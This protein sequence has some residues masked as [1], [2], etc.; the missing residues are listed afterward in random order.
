M[1][2]KHTHTH[3]SCY[4]H[5]ENIHGIISWLVTVTYALVIKEDLHIRSERS[6]WDFMWKRQLSVRYKIIKVASVNTVH[7]WH[8]SI[9]N[10]L[11]SQTQ[12]LGKP[13]II[14][15][16][17]LGEHKSF[18]SNF[19]ISIFLQMNCY[20]LSTLKKNPPA[21]LW[22]NYLKDLFCFSLAIT[23]I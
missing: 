17:F 21:L 2:L 19:I 13:Q 18:H 23:F 1:H 15:Y 12:N 11:S 9:I 6:L 14:S 5:Q 10:V 3:T 8:K 20:K 16:H 4:V 22:S 7:F